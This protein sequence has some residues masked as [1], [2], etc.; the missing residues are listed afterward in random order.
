M[1]NEPYTEGSV[2]IEIRRRG[3]ANNGA[4]VDEVAASSRDPLAALDKALAS[5]GVTTTDA[6][7]S[8]RPELRHRLVA[9]RFQP[10]H[11]EQHDFGVDEVESLLA[12]GVP[13]PAA[14]WASKASG[15]TIVFTEV[16]GAT[17]MQVAGAWLLLVKLGRVREWPVAVSTEVDDPRSLGAP[18]YRAKPSI[19]IAMSSFDAPEC[20]GGPRPDLPSLHE[21]LVRSFISR[22]S[23]TC[24]LRSTRNSLPSSCSPR[25]HSS[26]A[27]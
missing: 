17:A 15:L 26:C 9:L 4:G 24:L 16:D 13:L 25:G 12:D 11:D 7:L 6:V 10:P 3:G 22:I 5:A 21:A 19:H 8:W 27:R 18:V 23:A 1:N 20:A 2:S 14:A